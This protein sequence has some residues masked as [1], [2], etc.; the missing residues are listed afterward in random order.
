MKGNTINF[1]NS[2]VKELTLAKVI[3]T[4]LMIAKNKTHAETH[5]LVVCEKNGFMT[6]VH[7]K[8]IFDINP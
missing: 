7:P 5:Y 1:K 3:D 6:T 4:I 2:D 8:D